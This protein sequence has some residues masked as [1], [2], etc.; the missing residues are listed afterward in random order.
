MCWLHK[1]MNLSPDPQTLETS[2]ALCSS[3]IPVLVQRDRNVMTGENWQFQD[4]PTGYMW[5]QTKNSFLKQGQF[6]PT[7]DPVLDLTHVV[8]HICLHVHTICPLTSPQ[9]IRDYCPKNS[10]A[11]SEFLR[12]TD[13]I[14]FTTDAVLSL[15]QISKMFSGNCLTSGN[16]SACRRRA[17]DKL[18]PYR[19]GSNRS[20]L[21]LVH[22]SALCT[23]CYLLSRLGSR[24]N[25]TFSQ[26]K[27]RTCHQLLQTKIIWR[28][29]RIFW[30]NCHR[31][32][33]HLICFG[34]EGE[35]LR[36]GSGS[37]GTFPQAW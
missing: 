2:C 1:C 19:T 36:V 6:G 24:G 7:P 27:G 11:D 4:Q 16:N 21:P 12:D 23:P 15:L 32:I 34:V 31:F 37:K 3:V 18:S 35:A 26:G 29:Q 14:M 10:I 9:Y 8:A 30:S 13:Y 20:I 25:Y 33:E 28:I 5:Q 17:R 22:C